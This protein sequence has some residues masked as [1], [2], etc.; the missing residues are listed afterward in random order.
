M[1]RCV[2]VSLL[3]ALLA[4]TWAGAADDPTLTELLRRTHESAARGDLADAA[5]AAQA[6]VQARPGSADAHR[7]WADVLLR[8]NDPKAAL[9]EY[10]EAL[11][12]DPSDAE[13]RTRTAGL[14]L[15]D[16]RFAEA[17]AEAERAAGLAPGRAE[18]LAVL[19][20]AEAAL[21]RTDAALAALNRA[22][23]RAPGDEALRVELA[24]LHVT[25]NDPASAERDL[26]AGLEASPSSQ[27]LRAALANLLAAQRRFPEA[28]LLVDEVVRLAPDD[29]ITLRSASRY[30]LR[31]ADAAGA[32][33]LLHRALDLAG[34]RPAERAPAL[35][36]L[37]ELYAVTGR[38]PEAREA[39]EEVQR[40]APD[41][42]QAQLR[43]ANF[44]LLTDRPG[45]AQPWIDRLRA[46][47]ADDPNVRL[48][49]S[50]VDLAQGRVEQA[51]QT[52]EPMAEGAP[53][54]ATVQL[55]LGKAYAVGRRWDKAEQAYRRVLEEV[56]GHF[57]A[58]LD[59]AKVYLATGRGAEALEPISRV[60]AVQPDYAPGRRL[61]ADAWLAAG[62]PAEA[63]AAYR[64]L[65]GVKPLEDEGGLRT[66]LAASLEA[67]GH[68]PEALE[69]YSQ[70]RRLV[71]A[72]AE[73]ALRHVG[74]LD[75]LGKREEADRVS[76][77]YLDAGGD[78]LQALTTLA[79]RALE[80]RDRDLARALVARAVAA[81]P[82]AVG[83]RELEARLLLDDGDRT[84]AEAALRSVLAAEP[85]RVS[86]LLLLAT[87]L[88]GLGR[89]DEAAQTYEHVLRASPENAV[90][91]N[92]L[93]FLYLSDDAK[94][95]DA[96]RLALLAVEKA[97]RNP[98]TLDT[99]GWV[100]YR[101]QDYA[102]ALESL[103]AAHRLQP[104]HAE[105]AFHLGLTYEK[106]S[107]PSEARDVLEQALGAASG[108]S[109]APE[110]KAALDRLGRPRPVGGGAERGG[111]DAH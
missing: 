68:L 64:A 40:L 93:A 107:R 44:F 59:L 4:G 70:A 87:L 79:G 8:T 34:Q 77:G 21:G 20:R 88:E 3:W 1:L 80:R 19:A 56:P 30:R 95:P 36:E 97:P 22:I 101:S 58:N 72:S 90:A 29:P 11:R 15:L 16:R 71:P 2:V 99:L 76:R 38:L 67:Q 46:R 7:A 103:E 106:L 74:L 105:I 41:D 100:R 17:A 84:R 83:A 33:A 81:D 75:R 66:R 43:L 48:L 62:R 82:G 32:E 104:S 51:L 23:E 53:D 55:F 13:A 60:L 65:L 45:D 37:A 47:D 94:R 111:G 9:A 85:D 52:L 35:A 61:Q 49:Q 91:A 109:W 110:A 18:P 78:S 89:T 26:R 12:L 25:R 14:Y 5:R 108:A 92:N 6:A 24:R 10:G 50:R 69:Q 102:A 96:L 28:D 86:A 73:E 98:F 57:F 39:L 31:R 63:E 27:A 54:S 42:P